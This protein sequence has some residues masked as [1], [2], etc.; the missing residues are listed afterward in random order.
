MLLP[1]LPH[2]KEDRTSKTDEPGQF[3]AAYQHENAAGSSALFAEP[4]RRLKALPSIMAARVSQVRAP[5]RMISPC[6]PHSNVPARESHF[7]HA[8]QSTT[9]N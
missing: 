4:H 2:L 8:S 9:S 7:M 1:T 5:L 6:T 3:E